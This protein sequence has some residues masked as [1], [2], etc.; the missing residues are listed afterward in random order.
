MPKPM[1]F[2]E[3]PLGDG[4]HW[5]MFYDSRVLRWWHLPADR[6]VTL[7]IERITGLDGQVGRESKRQLMARFKNA[8][9][10]FALNAT[11]CT[12]IEQLYGADP[13]EWAG[14]RLVLYVTTTEMQ[15]KTVACIRVRP[16]RPKGKTG[17]RGEGAADDAA[18]LN[19]TASEPAPPAAD[20][21]ASWAGNPEEDGRG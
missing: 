21:T 4:K 10:P 3:T 5:R 8:R 11:N 12:T 9:L 17:P 20:P 18:A 15:G 13:H 16:S 6:D 1:E 19:E 7:T 14:K 2:T